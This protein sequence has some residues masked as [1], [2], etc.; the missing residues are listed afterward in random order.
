MLSLNKKKGKKSG[1][2]AKSP[3]F[4]KKKTQKKKKREKKK[5]Q[6]ILSTRAKIWKLSQKF[7]P[8]KKKDRLSQ[9]ASFFFCMYFPKSK[10][11]RHR[12]I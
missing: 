12:I 10:K 6:A 7:L 5:Y 11:K 3:N 1:F 2:K 9:E 8:Y 4:F